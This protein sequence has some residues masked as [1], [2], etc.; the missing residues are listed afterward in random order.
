VAEQ[1]AEELGHTIEEELNLLLV[2]GILHLLGYE[3][4]TDEGATVMRAREVVL[5]S[6]Y[7]DIA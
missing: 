3:H 4:D 7:E 6:A 2:H 5:L 1:Q